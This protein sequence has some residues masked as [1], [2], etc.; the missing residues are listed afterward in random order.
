M[1]SLPMNS[2]DF[3]LLSPEVIEIE[4]EDFELAKEI[5]G[6]VAVEAH[7]WQS[8]L[9]AVALLSFEKWLTE[10]M[11]GK[12]VERDI[13]KIDKVGYLNLKGFKFCLIAIEHLLDEIVSIPENVIYNFELAAHFYVLL[14]VLEE[15]EE[16]I[17]RGFL[18][19]DELV[20]YL[21]KGNVQS[22]LKGVYE[23]PFSA[24]DAEP[25]HLLSYCRLLEP[26]AIPLPCAEVETS[27]TPSLT[28]AAEQLSE[29]LK[30][31]RTKLGQ[32][33]EG[34]FESSWETIDTLIS[35]EA[36]VAFGV[37]NAESGAKRAKLIDLGMQ[38]ENQSFALLVTVT[39]E[40]EERLNISIQLHPM[41]E[42]K[43]L[44]PNVKLALLSKAGK[45]LQEVIS[46]SQDNY[47]QLKPFKGESGKRFSVEI[48]LNDVKIKE[49]FE[50]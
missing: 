37:R 50:F 46:R 4:T 2:S 18:R 29:C 41:R 13:T 8:Y 27:A 40:I 42:K 39:E 7:Q 38:L 35:P 19:S 3:R 28:K 32:W 16:V 33:L 31:T 47:I 45:I 49:D 24:F 22:Q 21:L 15:E 25:N 1:I 5:S 10:R 43:Y 30:E 6:E 44:P 20:N 12:I 26:S 34:I 23:I 17:V 36:M 9:N 11:P 48:S 14:E